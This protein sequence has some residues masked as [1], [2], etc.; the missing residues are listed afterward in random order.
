MSVGARNA[1]ASLGAL[2]TGAVLLAGCDYFGAAQQSYATPDEAVAALV[3]ATKSGDADG[4]VRVLGTEAQPV[5]Q[6]GDAIADANVRELF[7]E[8]Y[9]A[10][11]ESPKT[12]PIERFC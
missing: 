3:D 6:S 4:L 12:V 1:A 10:D 9:T 7:V 5:L 2:A 8:L 11:N